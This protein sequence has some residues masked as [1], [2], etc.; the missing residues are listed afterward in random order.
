MTRR[1]NNNYKKAETANFSERVLEIQNEEASSEIAVKNTQIQIQN[2][3][4]NPV[5]EEVTQETA[6]L[7]FVPVMRTTEVKNPKKKVRKITYTLSTNQGK[8]LYKGRKLRTFM[9]RTDL[10]KK[11]SFSAAYHFASRHQGSKLFK[12]EYYIS[13]TESK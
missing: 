8:T 1:F 6:R 3:V 11:F 2:R 10:N 12:G 5:L 4:N 9:K 7:E 13:F